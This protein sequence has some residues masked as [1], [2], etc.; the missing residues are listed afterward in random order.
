MRRDACQ[1]KH[2]ILFATFCPIHVFPT[3]QLDATA[4]QLNSNDAFVLLTPGGCFLWMGV[5]AS[6]G[7]KQGAQQLCDI[8]G[9]SA[10]ELL[11]GGESG[12]EEQRA[13][14]KGYSGLRKPSLSSFCVNQVCVGYRK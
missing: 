11:E 1:N 7:E 3:S 5:G 8:L 13:A 10:A 14:N 4:S 2:S 6:D 9:V 12:E